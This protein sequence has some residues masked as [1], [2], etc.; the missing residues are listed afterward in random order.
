M[1]SFIRETFSKILSIVGETIFL[2]PA[3][4]HYNG[5]LKTL[6][7]N[8]ANKKA[9]F[10]IHNS[11][12]LRNIKKITGKKWPIDSQTKHHD[13]VNQKPKRVT[14]IDTK[15][16]T[17]NQAKKASPHSALNATVNEDSDFSLAS[18]RHSRSFQ[19]CSVKSKV[20]KWN[21]NILAF[22]V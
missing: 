13:K 19:V 20:P 8:V 10:P 17:V 14:K 5:R 16:D 22:P 18:A 21:G 9:F 11:K 1:K 15:I 6:R 12:P 7:N 3:S 2:Q 4:F